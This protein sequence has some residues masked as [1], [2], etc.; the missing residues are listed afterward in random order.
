MRADTLVYFVKEGSE[1]Y[2]PTTGD[3]ITSEPIS[4]DKWANVSDLGEDRK[5]MLF[6]T[7]KERAKVVRLNS[8]YKDPFDYVLIDDVAYVVSSEKYFRRESVFYVGEKQ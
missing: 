5:A 6:G 7:I 8:L 3:Y 1:V 4:I 2:D